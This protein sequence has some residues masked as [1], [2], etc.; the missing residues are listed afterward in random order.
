MLSSKRLQVFALFLAVVG[1]GLAPAGDAYAGSCKSRGYDR[2]HNWSYDRGHHRSHVSYHSRNY[3]HGHWGHRNYNCRSYGH[4]RSKVSYKNDNFRFSVS[5]GSGR[6]Y[7]YHQPRHYSSCNKTVVYH[8]PQP[9]PT[10]YWKRVYHSPV[11]ETR[12]DSCGRAYRVTVRAGY[13]E[14]VWVDTG[15]RY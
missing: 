3:S 1:L 14:R 7:D 2:G 11:Y 4:S 6:H 5:V 10:G 9:K 15:Y 13:Y 12:Y 8:K